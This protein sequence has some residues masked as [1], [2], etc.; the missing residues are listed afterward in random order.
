MYNRYRP[1]VSPWCAEAVVEVTGKT[2]GI[3]DEASF[4]LLLFY[5]KSYHL[6]VILSRV[7]GEATSFQSLP[8]L[9]SGAV[10]AIQGA[11]GVLSI[12]TSPF[13]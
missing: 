7:A 11:L 1:L 10:C 5:S 9:C 12:V 8:F 6:S 4:F 13:C 3:L 2:E